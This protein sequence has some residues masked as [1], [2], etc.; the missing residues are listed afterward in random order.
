M[1]ER[2]RS[3]SLSVLLFVVALAPALPA[4]YTLIK[5]PRSQQLDYARPSDNRCRGCHSHQQIWSFNH[6]SPPQPNSGRYSDRWMRYYEV[7][8]W[9]ERFWDYRI[10]PALLSAPPSDRSS[11]PTDGLQPEAHGVTG[12]DSRTVHPTG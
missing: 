1:T 3:Y 2:Y 4:C 12:D 9:Y 6:A 8:W 10:P 11:L 5:H 7:P